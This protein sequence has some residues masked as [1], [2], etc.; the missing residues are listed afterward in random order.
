MSDVAEKYNALEIVDPKVL[1]LIDAEFVAEYQVVPTEIEIV[2]GQERVVLGFSNPAI[3]RKTDELVE[4][5][6]KNIRFVSYPAFLIDDAIEKYY[7]L[8]V[9]KE[10][11]AIQIVGREEDAAEATEQDEQTTS[12][13]N[14]L[15]SAILVTA[16]NERATDIHIKPTDSKSTVLF[17]IDG[18]IKDF[19][20]QC[21]ISRR[22]HAYVMRRIQSMCSSYI[23]ITNTRIPKDGSF[24]FQMK[25][26]GDYID[27]RISTIPVVYGEKMAIRILA[28]N[29]KLRNI[30]DLGLPEKD[31]ALLKKLLLRPSGLVVVSA[32]T[33][34]GKS[35]SVHAFIRLFSPRAVEIISLEDPVEERLKDVDQVSICRVADEK[36][37]LTAEKI[38]PALMRQDP[39]ILGVGEIR[40]IVTA[41]AAIEMSQTGHLTLT[42]LHA[43]N[44]VSSLARIF[45]LGIEKQDFLQEMV[46]LISQ[47][48]VRRTCPDC[49]AP[50]EIPAHLKVLLTQTE[51][52]ML[53][54]GSLMRGKGCKSCNDGYKGLIAVAEYIVFDNEI[55][56]FLSKSHGI[57][58]TLHFLMDQKG[59]VPLWDKALALVAT[60]QTSIEEVIKK[61]GPDR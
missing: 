18:E 43:R 11:A 54:R 61:V 1:A 3:L 53:E 55:R 37:S 24:Q 48:L 32:P 21:N 16:I 27:C 23:D 41:K 19:T 9:S 28:Q 49:A 44:C 34:Q 7:G 38:L 29:K 57:Q 56:D 8:S 17:R 2:S 6:G 31:T 59:Y 42:T 13:I 4:K 14:Q 45:G 10:T 22:E 52:E 30:E 15:V 58:E 51:T 35:T 33:N 60:G 12:A 26:S 47:R 20:E 5:I 46:C 40:D 25:E 50:A 36:V 39:D